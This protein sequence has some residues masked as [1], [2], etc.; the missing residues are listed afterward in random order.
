M[1]NVFRS[2]CLVVFLVGIITF[3]WGWEKRKTDTEPARSYV[4]V[5]FE[6][7]TTPDGKMTISNWRTTYVKA[8]GDFKT[9]F[10]G[11]DASAAF[12]NDATGLPGTSSPVYAKTSEGTFTKDIGSGERKSLSQAAPES[13][14]QL[15]RSHSFL[16]NSKNLV[17]MDKVAGFDVYVLKTV[18]EENPNYW[19]ET[20]VSPLTGRMP[21]RAV[22]HQADGN[23]YTVGAVKVEFKDVPNSLND[24]IEALPNTGKSG[25]KQ[26]VNT[27]HPN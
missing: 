14:E 25:E 7:H 19:V 8:N 16:K 10:H 11:A 2:L 12:A 1:K 27:K 9:V 6:S 18:N 21:L 22:V 24:D 20:S 15:Y 13:L 17:R 3:S 26:P 4:A 23:I 5:Y